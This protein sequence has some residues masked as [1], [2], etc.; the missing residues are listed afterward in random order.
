M[1]EQRVLGRALARELMLDETEAV[2]AAG[3]TRS[4]ICPDGFI[5]DFNF[6]DGYICDPD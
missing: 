1:R 3:V 4:C 2:A 6:E 5:T